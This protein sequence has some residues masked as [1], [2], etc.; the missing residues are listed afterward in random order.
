MRVRRFRSS[1][2][3]RGLRGIRRNRRWCAT[4]STKSRLP[5][6]L[7][8]SDPELRA[9]TPEC[10]P[11]NGHLPRQGRNRVRST[12]D[13][14]DAPGM[15]RPWAALTVARRRRLRVRMSEEIPQF[16]HSSNGLGGVSTPLLPPDAPY[17]GNRVC[18]RDS[19]LIQSHVERRWSSMAQANRRE[20]PHSIFGG[21]HYSGPSDFSIQSACRRKHAAYGNRQA[22]RVRLVRSKASG[23]DR[24]G[25]L[26][27]R[28]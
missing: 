28:C 20:F 17:E 9:R 2:G 24:R 18:G 8:A 10:P 3:P 21:W 6:P 1:P 14:P 27:D 23:P 5:A 25:S 7:G 16:A 22:A 11:A 15:V 26:P 13:L 19:R 12:P 4:H